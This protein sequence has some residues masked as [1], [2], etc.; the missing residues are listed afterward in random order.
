M[1]VVSACVRISTCYLHLLEGRRRGRLSAS[2]SLVNYPTNRAQFRLSSSCQ[3]DRK[4]DMAAF[5]LAFSPRI[6]GSCRPQRGAFKCEVSLRDE[7]S[8]A[9]NQASLTGRVRSYSRVMHSYTMLQVKSPEMRTLP[10]YQ[11]AMY[12]HTQGQMKHQ[13]SPSKARSETSSPHIL[14]QQAVLPTPVIAGLRQLTLDEAPPPPCSTPELNASSV[15]IMA[16]KRGVKPRSTTEPIPRD[17]A[18]GA[19]DRV[20]CA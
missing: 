15:P 19:Q 1:P 18:M 3:R 9:Q 5:N 10:E 2:P 17:F 6:T 8:A 4:R 11:K 20:A 16:R 13:R 7:L 14:A 12:E